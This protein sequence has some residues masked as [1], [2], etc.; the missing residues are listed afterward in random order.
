MPLRMAGWYWN[1]DRAPERRGA[2]VAA[3]GWTRGQPLVAPGSGH[4]SALAH[5]EGDQWPGPA[6]GHAGIAATRAKRVACAW[7]ARTEVIPGG[8]ARAR[9]NQP[10]RRNSE[11]PVVTIRADRDGHRPATA[12]PR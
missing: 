12:Q 8:T 10:G 6:P 2:P 1:H 5:T 9:R 4:P 11:W 7:I 3:L